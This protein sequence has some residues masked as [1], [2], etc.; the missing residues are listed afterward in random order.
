LRIFQESLTVQIEEQSLEF[1]A[2]LCDLQC[3]LSLKTRQKKGLI[4]SKF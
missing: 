4:F 2:E 3:D 1:Q